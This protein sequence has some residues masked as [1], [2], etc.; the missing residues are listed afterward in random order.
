MYICSDLIGCFFMKRFFPTLFFLLTI[1]VAHAQID[2]L[3]WFA[4]PDITAG[5]QHNPMTFCVTSFSNPATVVISQPAN[6]SFTPITINLNPYSYYALDV[7]AQENIVETT[8]NNTVC[9]TGFKIT[10]TANISAY[11]QTGANNSEIY[12]LKGRNALGTEFVV[13]M[14]NFLN[15]GN[16]TPQALSSVE[17]VATEDNTTVVITP[18]RPLLGGLP[19]NVPITITLNQGQTYAIKAAST[20]A[21][22]HLTNTRIVSNK[23]IAVNSSDDSAESNSFSGYSGQD[24]VGEQIVPIEYAGTFYIATRNGRAFE[25]LVVSPIYDSTQVFINGNTNPAATLGIHDSYTYML[26]QSPSVATTV[27]TSK[28]AFVFELTGS[29][30]ECGGTVLPAIGCTG[31]QE[32]VYA[33]PSYSTNMKLS[34]VVK[35]SDIGG[36]TVNNSTTMLS[37]NDFSPVASNPNWSY[38]YKDFSSLIPTQTVM[39]IKNNLGPFHLGILDYYTGMSS[40]LGYF[41]GYNPMGKILLL[42]NNTYCYGE[43][44]EFTYRASDV[45]TIKLI[46]P[47]GDTLLNPPFVIE[48]ITPQDTGLYYIIAHGTMVCDEEWV[49]DSVY[50]H[51]V[52][53][54]KPDLGPDQELCYGDVAHIVSN[55]PLTDVNYY[56]NT[57]DN[58]PNISVATTGDY[59]LDV[60]SQNNQTQS[61]CSNSDTIHISFSPIPFPDFDVDGEASGCAPLDVKLLNLTEPTNV[62][63]D[64]VW[65][66]LDE[67]GHLVFQSLEEDPI[68]TFKDP[69]TY[70]VVLLTTTDK[71]CV[72]SLYKWNMIHTYLQPEVDFS[73][74]PSV[75][76]MSENGGLAT[77]QSYLSSS[78]TDS[79]QLNVFWDFG[80]GE[81]DSEN[82]NPTHAY[83]A[84]GDYIANLTIS[85]EGDCKAEISHT[86]I[87]EAD[88]I[89]PNIIT[90]NGDGSNDVF[91]IGNLNTDINY[92]DPD[93]YRTNELYIYD[94]W[95]QLVFKANNYDTYSRDSQIY[96]GT[97][98]FTGDNLSDGVYYYVFYYKGHYK[99]TKYNGSITIVR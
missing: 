48:S 19:A 2:D 45:D 42:M 92:E 46:T 25:G 29:D 63:M 53:I 9:N 50:L 20:A 5:H 57:G 62:T 90:P 67:G 27:S 28:P 32:V 66:V 1:F 74:S 13:P 91:A 60:I 52:N 39:V 86:V 17:I 34:V 24:L 3:F 78:I 8:P 75:I 64:Y 43:R 26:S 81:T 12:T 61:R 55:Y 10:S 11:Y 23:P 72:D 14:Q 98:P 4:A 51:I 16:F 47:S 15:T 83:T 85:T 88:L 7:T 56:W 89:F 6:P 77:F 36:F 40:S 58:T 70:S 99:E 41:S 79:S 73:F 80:D 93:D 69:G 49:K 65:T 76:Y 21:N 71:G 59:I 18:S 35:T 22:A 94:R 38:C 33:R 31:S 97:N 87:V 96:V 54:L 84:W 95:G 82:F 44:V 37:A 30:G 68:F